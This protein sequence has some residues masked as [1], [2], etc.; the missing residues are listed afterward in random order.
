MWQAFW[1]DEEG[2]G[3]AEY[4]VIVG[5]VAIGAIGIMKAFMNSMSNGQTGIF[6]RII[7]A[8]QGI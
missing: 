2:Q 6:P 4:G 1:Q 5:I 3:L 8:L 7:Q